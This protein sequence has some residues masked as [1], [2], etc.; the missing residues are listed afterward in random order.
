MASGL[1]CGGCGYPDAGGDNDL[2]AH[3]GFF[4]VARQTS[5]KTE[6]PGADRARRTPVKPFDIPH[7]RTTFI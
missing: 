1:A 5:H 4:N 2:R 6:P 7:S 3:H